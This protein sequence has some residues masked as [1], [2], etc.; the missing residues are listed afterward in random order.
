MSVHG[1]GGQQRCRG[2]GVA[3]VQNLLDFEKTEKECSFMQ[4]VVKGV[5]ELNL[6]TRGIPC[7][8]EK[9]PGTDIEQK[10]LARN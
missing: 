1:F 9:P 4:A 3:V 8:G 5:M 7:R 10:P 6:R 2:P